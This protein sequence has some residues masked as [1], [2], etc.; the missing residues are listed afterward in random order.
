VTLRMRMTGAFLVVVLGPV[1][2]GAI[3]VGVAFNEANGSRQRDQLTSA[4]V[5]LAALNETTCARLTAAAETAAALATGPA[6]PQAAQSV[7]ADGRANAV[8]IRTAAGDAQPATVGAPSEPWAM[9]GSPGASADSR[10]GPAGYAALAAAA[11]MSGPNGTVTGY[12]YA[13]AYLDTSFARSLAAAIGVGV[14]IVNAGDLSSESQQAANHISDAAP[15]TGDVTKAGDQYVLRVDPSTG[16]PLSFVISAP[17]RH[18]GTPYLVLG[19]VVLVSALAALASSWA[20]ARTT[21]RPLHDIADAAG[22][23]AGGDLDARVPVHRD[24]EIGRVAAAVNRLTREMQSYADGLNASR[25]QLRN[26]LDRLG[27]ALAGT[28]DLPRLLSATLASAVTATSARAGIIMLADP[29][30]DRLRLECSQGF[31]EYA[32]AILDPLVVRFGEGLTGGVA[33][34]GVA[35]RGRATLAGDTM[36]PGEPTCETYL[37]VPL[38]VEPSVGDRSGIRGVL[39]LYDRLGQPDFDATD[40]SAVESLAAG[41]AVAV[42]NVRQ[43]DEAKRLSHTDPLTGLYNYRHLKDVLRRETHRAARFDHSLAVLVM[44]LDRFKTI[45]DR[46]GHAAG[47]AVLVEFARRVGLEIRGVDVAFRYGGEEFVLLLPETDAIGGTTVAQRLGAAI[48]DTAVVVPSG[49]ASDLGGVVEI[50]VSVSIG[51]AVYPDH[52][53]SGPRVLEAADDALYAA[54]A[55]GRDTYRLAR[56]PRDVEPS[57]APLPVP[58]TLRATDVRGEI[59]IE[60]GV[61]VAAVF[62]QTHVAAENAE[63]RQS[64]TRRRRSASGTPAAPRQGRGR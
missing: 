9:C 46:Y 42:D 5:S 6:G 22:R 32:S 33:S 16:Q 24:D 37:A 40:L 49:H 61:D 20:I 56:S 7:V 45:N 48:R 2:T 15:S 26:S 41:A 28:H 8:Q 64:R 21:I 58:A 51:V 60:V 63:P 36:A 35:R 30:D 39:A 18:T 54:K 23:V 10:S 14:T 17:A 31:D 44:D 38:R 4:A 62:A 43:H 1:S 55:A 50:N 3:L 19:A 52:G 57:R 13:I 12:A 25:D 29:D 11:P 47:D 53:T 27:D 59:A 34:D